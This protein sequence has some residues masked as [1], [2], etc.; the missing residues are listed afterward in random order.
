MRRAFLLGGG[1]AFV[2]L[3]LPRASA[4]GAQRRL[5]LRHAATGAT[6]AGPWHDGAVPDPVA[7][8]DLS[9]AL[10]DPGCTPPLPFDPAT[11]ALLCDIAAHARLGPLEIRSGYRTAQVNRRVRGAGDSLHIRASAVD[12]G[13]PR[14]RLWAVAEMALRLGRG[15]VGIYARSSFLHLDT[16][17]VRRWGDADRAG[18]REETLA[19]IAE[20]WARG[21]R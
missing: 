18:K 16:G 12:L 9:A 6:F 7:M 13:V 5:V 20:A 1:A 15:G 19:R 3:I 21:G 17:P 8:R 10:A 14:D 4:A 11:V 2:T